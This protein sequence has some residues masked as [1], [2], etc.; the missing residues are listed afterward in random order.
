MEGITVDFSKLIENTPM[1]AVVFL[2]LWKYGEKLDKL[3][4]SIAKL[5]EN[6][7]K[8]ITLIELGG[9]K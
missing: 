7:V 5:S 3:S 9:K 8:V 1:A 4:E 6:I 2:L